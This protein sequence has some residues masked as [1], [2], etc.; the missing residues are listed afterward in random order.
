MVS[1]TVVKLEEVV[2]QQNS[3][4]GS[5][6]QWYQFTL[7]GAFDCHSVIVRFQYYFIR[8]LTLLHTLLYF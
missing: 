1:V 6:T 4:I 3:A 5:W 8:L 7:S 2:S